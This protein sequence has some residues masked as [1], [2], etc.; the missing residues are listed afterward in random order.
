MSE[1]LPYALPQS[2]ARRPV[3]GRVWIAWAVILISAA[4]VIVGASGARE[5][6]QSGEMASNPQLDL[7]CRY[8][9]GAK[10]LFGRMASAAG[11]GN[12]MAAQVRSNAA[13]SLDRFRIIPVIYELQGRDAAASAAGG[14][15]SDGN[16]ATELRGDARFL[17]NAYLNKTFN[18]E[19]LQRLK[20]R[21]GW[22]GKLAASQIDPSDIADREAAESAA[23]TTVFTLIGAVVLFGMLLLAGIILL[24][25]FLVARFD[26][27]LT[28]QFLRAEPVAADVLAEGFAVYMGLMAA[29]S[30]AASFLP[31]HHPGLIVL[32][33]IPVGAALAWVR[34]RGVWGAPLMAAVGWH[35]GRGVGRE[36]IAGI[37]GYI[38]GL[39]L[40]AIGFGLFAFLSRFSATRATHPI[41][42]EISEGGWIRLL[43]IFLACVFAPVTEELMFRGMLLRHLTVRW[44][45]IVSAVVLS[46]IFAAIHPQGWTAI[47]VL[48]AIGFVLAMIRIERDSL[49]A[50]MTAHAFNNAL[51][52]TIFI[53]AAG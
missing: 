47:P 27:K 33:I 22:Y 8:A 50:S 43:L 15:E 1:I 52:I 41:E 31:T 19:D 29:L 21:Y 36:M 37:G 24:V 40:M 42:Y 16:A 25:L 44:R 35:R 6:I 5:K 53:L 3:T 51:V 28:P 18:S 26:G 30:F 46:L 34:A 20:S 49:I 38:A 10:L 11:S 4:V 48:G 39:P 14:V 9:V 13:D 2:P 23:R 17:E 7:V 45:P 32:L 12:A